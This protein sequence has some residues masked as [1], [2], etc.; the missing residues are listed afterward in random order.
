[1][2]AAE[3]PTRT[4]LQSVKA[5]LQG[6][7]QLPCDLV[8]FGVLLVWPC[9]RVDEDSHIHRGATLFGPWKGENI[10]QAHTSLPVAV[11]HVC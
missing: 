9:D 11:E 4:G 8:V 7:L 5:L 2:A 6:S 3:T 1:M 10:K